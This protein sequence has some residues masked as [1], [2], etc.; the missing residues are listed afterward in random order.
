MDYG[1]NGNGMYGEPKQNILILEIGKKY[2]YI[3]IFNI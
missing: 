2:S 1:V 3:L